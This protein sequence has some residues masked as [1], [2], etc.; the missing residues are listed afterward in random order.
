MGLTEFSA[1]IQ[2]SP[3]TLA[4]LMQNFSSRTK[5]N[6][7]HLILQCFANF[8]SKDD[9]LYRNAGEIPTKRLSELSKL[10]NIEVKVYKQAIRI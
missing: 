1:F 7:T 9:L 6:E 8:T 2:C 10:S 5:D 4:L 3:H